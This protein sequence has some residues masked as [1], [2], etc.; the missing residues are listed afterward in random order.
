MMRQN[1]DFLA[2]CNSRILTLYL[3][4]NTVVPVNGWNNSS[5]NKHLAFQYK[6]HRYFYSDLIPV[7][8][9]NASEPSEHPHT[10]TPL[11]A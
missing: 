10:H 2:C 8:N 3:V 7:G 4:C 5:I 6:M 11:S 1:A 9:L